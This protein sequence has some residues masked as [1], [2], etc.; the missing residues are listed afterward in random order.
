[1]LR[2]TG[3]CEGNSP[4]TGESPAQRASNAENVYI[5]WHHHGEDKTIVVPSLSYLHND[6]SSTRKTVLYIEIGPC[7]FPP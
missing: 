3:I 1:M 4:V 7:I 2:V 5:W 6:I